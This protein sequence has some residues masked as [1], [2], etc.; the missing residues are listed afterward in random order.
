MI[1]LKKENI[2]HYAN[3]MR[4]D[5][6]VGTYL[7]LWPCF[8]AIF[9]AAERFPPLYIIIIFALGSFFMRSAGCVI[10]DFADRNFDGQVSRTKNRPLASKKITSRE[11]I[12]LFLLLLLCSATLLLFLKKITALWALGAVTIATVYPFMKRY[13]HLPQLVLGMAFS[14]SIP[15]AFIELTGQTP[16]SCWILYF[17]VVS[18][19]IAYDTFYAMVDCEDDLKAGIKSTAILFGKKDIFI[20]TLLQIIF[21]SGM[22]IVGFINSLSLFYFIGI[23][24]A[25]LLF[26]YQHH[27]VKTREIENYFKAFKNNHYVGLVIFIGLLMDKLFFLLIIS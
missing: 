2:T 7:L 21:I 17:C 20:A 26:V 19:V 11:A 22:C 4:L 10:N 13:T 16:L 5:K 15:M 12:E 6:P 8:W 25:S 18:W 3:L 24:A 14:W 1:L 9:I 27:L 23:T